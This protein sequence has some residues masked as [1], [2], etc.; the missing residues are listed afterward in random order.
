T[1][2]YNGTNSIRWTLEGGSLADTSIKPINT[3]KVTKYYSLFPIVNSISA[4]QDL[5]I[6]FTNNDADFNVDFW[7]MEIHIF[8]RSTLEIRNSTFMMSMDTSHKYSI[9]V[10]N[11]GLL[12]IVNSVMTVDITQSNPYF[13]LYIDV[14]DSNLEVETSTLKFPGGINITNG[15]FSLL[16][17]EIISLDSPHTTKGCAVLK[18]ESGNIYFEESSV[19]T[20]LTGK[21][22]TL[23]SNSKFVGINTFLDIDFS[24]NSLLSVSGNTMAYLFNVTTVPPSYPPFSS[25]ISVVGAPAEAQVYRWVIAN[26]SDCIDVP[27]G[28]A[29]V[30]VKFANDTTPDKPLQEALDYLGLSSNDY[31][32]D[33]NGSTIIPLL[34]DILTSSSMPNSDYVGNYKLTATYDSTTLGMVNIGLPMYPHIEEFDN[35]VYKGISSA[36]ELV[37]PD[38][39]PY[40]ESSSVADIVISSGT[41]TIKDSQYQKPTGGVVPT[42][43]QKGNTIV[44]NTG[45]LVVQ[46]SLVSFEQNSQNKYFIMVKDNG[47]LK[48]QNSIIQD[49]IVSPAVVPINIYLFDN[50]KLILEQNSIA[51]DIGA[52]VARAGG[53]L[54]NIVIEVTNSN[55]TGNII[56]AIG[57]E[58]SIDINSNSFIDVGSMIAD[59]AK[60][61]IQNSVISTNYMPSFDGAN[62]TAVNSSFNQ[63]LTFSTD[64]N[65]I[66]ININNPGFF[67]ITAVGS[68]M[69]HVYWWLKVLVK[70]S[71]A[72]PLADADVYLWNYTQEMEK[73]SI[74]YRQGSTNLNGEVTFDVLGGY[75][76]SSGYWYGGNIGNY[77]INAT[78][79][80]VSSDEDGYFNT[81]GTRGNGINVFG[82]NQE[83]EIVI[84]GAPDLVIYDNEIEYDPAQPL[85]DE[86]VNL[87]VTV[88]NLGKFG[89]SNVYVRF[90]DLTANKQIGVDQYITL[91]DGGTSE[92]VSIQWIPDFAAIHD[93]KISADPDNIIGETNENN[94]NGTI[95]IDI[96]SPPTYAD[97]IVTSI[98]STPAKPATNTKVKLNATILNIGKNNAGTPF[99]VQFFDGDPEAGGELIDEEQTIDYL[100]MDSSANVIVEWFA[101]TVGDHDIYV[102]VDPEVDT[103]DNIIGAIEESNETNNVNFKTIKVVEGADLKIT[104][105]DITTDP[106]S[107]ITRQSQFT[108]KATVHNVGGS[109]ASDITV[110]FY[111]DNY[112][113]PIGDRIIKYIA[114]GSSGFAYL[115]WSIEKREIGKQILVWVDPDENLS[116]VDYGNNFDSTKVDIVNKADLEVQSKD[117]MVGKDP[118]PNSVDVTVYAMVRNSGET[119]AYNVKVRFFYVAE[120]TN[121]ETQIGGDII[122]AEFKYGIT[123]IMNLSV[124]W[125]I[126]TGGY[127]DIVVQLIPAS[128]A[129]DEIMTNNKAKLEEVYV[130]QKADLLIKSIKIEP[131]N[132]IGESQPFS[133]NVTVQNNGDSDVRNVK[134]GFYKGEPQVGGILI[135]PSVIDPFKG[136]GTQVNVV[137]ESIPIIIPL[138][139]GTNSIY[140]MVDYDNDIIEEDE[141]NNIGKVDIIVLTN[142]ADLRFPD[143]DVFTVNGEVIT[144]GSIPSFRN[145]STVDINFTIINDGELDAVNFTVEVFDGDPDLKGVSI[146]ETTVDLLGTSK[147]SKEMDI[148]ITDWQ[149][150]WAGDHEVFVVLNPGSKIN[151]TDYRNN[152]ENFTLNIYKSDLKTKTADIS[153]ER[154]GVAIVLIELLAEEDRIVDGE[155]IVISTIV[156]NNGEREETVDIIFYASDPAIAGARV[157]GEQTRV[158]PA[159][160]DQKVTVNWIATEGPFRIFVVVDPDPPNEILESNEKNNIAGM[161]SSFEVFAAS[162]AKDDEEGFPLW[163][164]LSI[165]MIIVIVI[166]VIVVIYFMVVVR[167]RRKTMAECSEC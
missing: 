105:E 135:H 35:N 69:I 128:E 119:N 166:I 92:D 71:R 45:T 136:G 160:E 2:G 120:G 138:G 19:R 47:T 80:G 55:I 63:D 46:D 32:T 99:V 123:N 134:V 115:P 20:Y 141:D 30:T 33:K 73:Y 113:N 156:E 43:G 96:R 93:I 24:T 42:Y 129:D 29:T 140:I 75:I 104:K 144:E 10:K 13:T 95:S 1:N 124:T 83:V 12:R 108:I 9:N 70:D 126:E 84:N 53:A 106:G 152:I 98:Q 48:L 41:S 101:T 44:E 161:D 23:S 148:N 90:F 14:M 58:I 26:V 97:L 110:R 16:Q 54:N 107:P 100:E 78:Y 65:V 39:N 158:I 27:V 31:V 116:D 34:S 155:T 74:P 37:A 164:M 88:H 81:R 94:N 112:G 3:S 60:I 61:L 137:Y 51:Q 11:G 117:I 121:T 49:G 59:D 5:D 157:I 150:A 67:N 72:N 127:Y 133:I 22:I 165:I 131:S 147:L 21:D 57:S 143:K 40:Y 130:L 6:E 86:I 77:Y 66:L 146:F 62:F 4:I 36:T 109:S 125:N 122:I 139:E 167:K 68:T 79:L 15:N 76:D 132:V 25:A 50:A 52:I 89:A 7:D 87:T 18:F 85:V 17:S 103:E 151:E 162:K 154:D 114:E 64:Y 118:V 8:E 91:V 82:G 159:S 145:G 142:E 28:N 149:P 111:L 163:M 153:L 102:R 56:D 38:N